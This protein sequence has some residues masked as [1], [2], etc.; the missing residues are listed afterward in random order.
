MRRTSSD[1]LV[2]GGAMQSPRKIPRGDQKTLIG[3]GG[4]KEG[5]APEPK[6]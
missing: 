1:W 2:G 6:G 4:A 3:D 5:R